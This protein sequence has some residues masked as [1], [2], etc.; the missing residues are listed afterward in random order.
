MTLTA[1]QLERLVEQL[2]DVTELRD[3]IRQAH[4]ATRDLRAA[5]REANDVTRR[6]EAVPTKIGEAMHTEIAAR[7]DQLDRE[8]RSVGNRT[9]AQLDRIIAD[10]LAGLL[11]ITVGRPD[12]DV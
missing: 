2:E 10:H 1:A 9:V 3:I 5:I 11:D 6:A 4:E 7:F 8:L 12:D